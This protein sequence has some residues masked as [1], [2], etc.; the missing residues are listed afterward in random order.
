MKDLITIVSSLDKKN[1]FASKEQS[2]KCFDSKPK[3]MKR[4]EVSRQILKHTVMD[5][6]HKQMREDNESKNAES[7][8]KVELNKIKELNKSL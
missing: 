4:S 6:V 8:S 3:S 5:K 1:E 2:E 7:D